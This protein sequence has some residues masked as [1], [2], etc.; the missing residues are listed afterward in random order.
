MSPN[1]SDRRRIAARARGVGER[2][3]TPTDDSKTTDPDGDEWIAQ[4]REHVADD[5]EAFER[6]LDI[7][8]ESLETCR[9]RLHSRAIPDEQ[10]RPEWVGTLGELLDY[11]ESREPSDPPPLADAADDV[12]FVELLARVVAFASERVEWAASADCLSDRARSS[13]ERWLLD[14][15][16]KVAAHALFIEFK[17]FLAS[18]DRELAFA[19][20]P[21]M[22]DSP[23]RYYDQFVA[24]MHEG[25]L[26]AL[27]EE[28]STLARLVVTLTDQ[29]RDA[30]ETFCERLRDD[31]EALT[32]T[33]GAGSS[34]GTVTDLDYR[35]DHHQGGRVVFHLTFE[36]GVELAYKPRDVRPEARFAD[37][38]SWVNAE[39]DLE[40]LAAL[41]CLT[42]EGYGWMAW[43]DS[44]PCSSAAA[45]GR[46]YRR[47]GSVLCLLYALNFV[48]GHIEN[49]VAAGEHP[50]VVDLETLMHPRAPR[51][52]IPPASELPE[53]RQNTVLR[54]GMVPE[55]DPSDDVQNV[56]GFD[57]P[58]GEQTGVQVP[59]FERVN[60]DVMELRYEESVTVSGDSLPIFDGSRVEPHEYGETLADGFAET[61][62]FLLDNEGA[63][64]ADDGPV[65][66]F[67]DAELRYVYRPSQTYQSVLQPL[68]TPECLR[69]GRTLGCK[70]ERLAEPFAAGDTDRRLWPVYEAERT[71]LWRA[72][73]PRFS[74]RADDT[75]L[76]HDGSPV[77]DLFD[78]SPLEQVRRRIDGF[79]ESDLG[80]QLDLIRTAYGSPVSPSGDASGAVADASPEETD[81]LADADARREARA[82]FERVRGAATRAPDGTP[83]WHRC[84]RGAGGVEL[85]AVGDDFYG[86][87]LGIAT[88]CGALAEVTGDAQCR[89]FAVEVASPVARDLNADTDALAGLDVGAGTGMGSYVYGFAVLGDLLDADRFTEAARRS[90]SLLTA[91][92]FA[93]DAPTEVQSGT[94]GALLALLA[95]Y[96]RTGDDDLLE[97]ATAAGERLLAERVE[98]DGARVWQPVA[99]DR[100]LTGMAHG[101]AGIAYAL[102]RLFG[103]TGD[104]RFRD[105]ATDALAYEDAAYAPEKRNWRDYRPD[106][107][108]EFVTGWCG[109]RSGVGLSRLG[110]Y[111]ATGDEAFLEDAERALAGTDT[112]AL[113]DFDHLC[114]GN[115]SQVDFLFEAGRTLDDSRYSEDARRLAAATVRR[116]RENGR[117]TVPKRTDNWLNPSLFTGE[118]G[119]GYTLLR[120]DD[121]QLPCVT[122][123]E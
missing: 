109:G 122:L 7:E 68:T 112:R 107:D 28:Y 81:P 41:D 19:D 44:E 29:W 73:T 55:D 22:P 9:Q 45:I 59:T 93:G 48:D 86:G 54:T 83:T 98:V 42:R 89:E 34:L 115:F 78:A 31:W 70:V 23:R 119:V 51:S 91:E 88:F 114:C 5:P 16:G 12:P 97:R 58:A 90:A 38:V 15:L 43:A 102:T 13:L 8:G 36:S 33:F 67:A 77:A 24:E 3:R 113:E 84:E 75:T 49:V 71:A 57:A 11:V 87:R 40:D 6:R 72:D 92:R 2:L 21:E 20:D 56:A 111:D 121:P 117:L 37:L 76:R 110:M 100:V 60:T 50:V 26:R 64:L 103:A 101:T 47:A 14:R 96:D 69:D 25:E 63:L 61:Y 106:I 32:E 105:A 4:W 18:Q 65:A 123:W 99:G 27:F 1:N 74:V 94:A 82:I 39:S 10:S 95:L 104:E 52:A 80:E 79:S 66:A 17:T 35:G 118:T 85:A 116:A 108:A 30:V 120:L 46:Y 62:R 53:R